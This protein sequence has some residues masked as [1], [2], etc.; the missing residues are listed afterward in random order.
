[1]AKSKPSTGYESSK[2][3]ILRFI[4]KSLPRQ[5]FF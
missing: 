3:E 5:Y 2:S 4:N 1:M